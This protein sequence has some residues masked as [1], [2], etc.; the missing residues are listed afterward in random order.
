MVRPPTP[1]QCSADADLTTS[2]AFGRAFAT[3]HPQWGGYV[4]KCRV[5]FSPDTG[6]LPCFMVTNW[7]TGEFPDDAE[8]FAIHYCDPLQLA[9]FGALIAEK[10]VA[11]GC[12]PD[13]HERAIAR[14]LAEQ[15][16]AIATTPETP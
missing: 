6:R 10:M 9:R 16:A 8:P 3:W 4:G 2:H 7:H 15:F 11:A 12:A 13:E 1:E 5:E 14:R